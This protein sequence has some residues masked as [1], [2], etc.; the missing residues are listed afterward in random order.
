[1]RGFN[2]SDK[3]DGEKNYGI[4]ELVEDIRGLCQALEINQVNLAGHD[5]GG[6]VA[7][8][9]AE[10]HP[11]LLNKLIIL[12]A[13]HPKIFLDSLQNDK[14]QQRASSYIFRFQSEG[15]DFLL[16]NNYQFLQLAVFAGP[17]NQKAFSKE[18]KEKYFAAWSQPS[19][20]LAGVNYYRA[21]PHTY[22]GSGII[23]VPTLVIWGLKDMFLLPL[24]LERMSEL[25]KNLKIIRCENGSHWILHD[26]PDLVVAEIKTFINIK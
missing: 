13:P 16:E 14:K 11:E 24:Q 7:W 1:M 12:N 22:K 23:D 15:G 18:D 19:A 25:V 10:Q 3:P 17:R 6:L 26:E 8:A 21:F 5:W 4:R 9:F 2:L 20:V